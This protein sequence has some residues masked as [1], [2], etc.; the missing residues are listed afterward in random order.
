MHIWGD[1]EHPTPWSSAKQPTGSGP[2]GPYWDVVLQTSAKHVGLLI[3]KG[4]EKAAGDSSQSIPL[5][6][7]MQ[8][9]H[10]PTDRCLSERHASKA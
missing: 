9:V 4:E 2:E 8:V 10:I 7:Q 3:H 6:K 1:V 5:Q